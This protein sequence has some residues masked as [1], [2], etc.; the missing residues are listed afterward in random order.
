MTKK[1]VDMTLRRQAQMQTDDPIL[2]LAHRVTKLLAAEAETTSPSEQLCA[3]ELSARSVL[4]VVRHVHGDSGVNAVHVD[5]Q[6]RAR[7][8]AIS[9]P[10]H[11]DDHTVFDDTEVPDT[12]PSQPE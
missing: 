6:H 7:Q 3:L 12:Q 5:A 2:Q 4:E 9:W 11:S 10:E 8:Y 1:I